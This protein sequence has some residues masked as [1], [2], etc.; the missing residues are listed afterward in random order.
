VTFQTEDRGRS[1]EDLDEVLSQ[2]LE[3]I[4]NI[5]EFTKKL[6]E[7]IQKAGKET[8]GSR[9][10]VKQKAKGRTNELTIMRKKTNA[11]RRRYQGQE[12]MKHYG[13]VEGPNTIKRK[14]NNK[15]P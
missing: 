12:A 2:K 7:A 3:A 10:T 11:L 9:N 13:R 1:N 5:Q 6:E 14:R 4:W 15:R 8:S